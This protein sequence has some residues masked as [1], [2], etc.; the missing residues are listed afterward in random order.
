MLRAELHHRLN[1]HAGELLTARDLQDDVSYD[2]RMRGLHVRALHG[3]WGVALGFE[4]FPTADQKSLI[5]TQGIAYDCSGREIVLSDSLQIGFVAPPRSSTAT[6]WWF[7]LLIK[8][9]TS[10]SDA[11]VNDCSGTQRNV[12]PERPSWRWSYAGEAPNPFITPLGFADDV[13]LG[14]EIPLIRVRVTKLGTATDFDLTVRRV[15]RSLAGPNIATGQVRAGSVPITGSPLRWQARIDTSAGGFTSPKPFYSATLSEHPFIGSTSGFTDMV[16]EK[17]KKELLGPFVR[18]ESA[19][20]TAFTIDVQTATLRVNA[21]QS[22]PSV[23]K[24][25]TGFTLPVTVNWL[26]IEPSGG[27][28]PPPKTPRW[29]NVLKALS[30][31]NLPHL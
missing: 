15:A 20:R 10:L 5:V 13:R 8:Y 1:H 3:V 28:P 2:A 19:T 14:E 23:M 27:C 4:V 24:L 22:M 18:I 16:P 21:L 12:V 7:D 29:L 6:E 26:G 25:S 31:K 30:I 11:P 17:T 9:D